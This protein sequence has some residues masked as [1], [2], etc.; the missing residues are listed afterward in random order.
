MLRPFVQRPDRLG[1]G[2]IERL[3]AVAPHVHQAD[4]A[5]HLRCFETDGCVEAERRDDVADGTFA[6]RQVD[7]DVAPPRLRRWR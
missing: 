6:R 7:E 5:Q 3:P 2:A 1:V 4:V